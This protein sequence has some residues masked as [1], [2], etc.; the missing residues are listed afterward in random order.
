MQVPTLSKSLYFS[1]AKPTT[2]ATATL[3]SKNGISFFHFMMILKRFQIVSKNN[4]LTYQLPKKSCETLLSYTP[5][6]VVQAVHNFEEDEPPPESVPSFRPCFL[7]AF[8]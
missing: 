1:A 3:T 2:S 8:L 6:H 5:S 4:S 7:L